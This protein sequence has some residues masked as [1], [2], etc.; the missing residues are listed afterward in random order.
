MSEIKARWN[1]GAKGEDE[2]PVYNSTVVEVDLGATLDEAIELFGEEAVFDNY[3]SSAKIQFQN[4]IRTL[5][6]A[7]VEADEIAGKLVDWKLG[8]KSSK[9]VADPIAVLKQRYAAA[10]TQE[11]KDSILAQIMGSDE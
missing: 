4:A 6:E 2:K 11:E 3:F 7:G 10:G 9:V 8:E 1:T 5:G